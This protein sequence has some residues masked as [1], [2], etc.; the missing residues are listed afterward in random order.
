MNRYNRYELI[1]LPTGIKCYDRLN[2]S[3]VDYHSDIEQNELLPNF[4]S[5]RDNF[6]IYPYNALQRYRLP[7]WLCFAI[8]SFSPILFILSIVL[9]RRG[10]LFNYHINFFPSVLF[11]P[12]LLAISIFLHELAHAVV[13]ISLGSYVAEIGLAKKKRLARYYTKACWTDNDIKQKYLYYASGIAMNLMLAGFAV[14]FF[15]LSHSIIFFLFFIINAVFAVLNAIPNRL[16]N[17]DG[18][19]LMKSLQK[20]H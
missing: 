5:K 18:Y 20:K 3:F 12:L 10:F 8:I 4:T 2:H 14:I 15:F 13:G 9:C 11:I 6:C 19:L 17:S 7:I 16:G 1:S